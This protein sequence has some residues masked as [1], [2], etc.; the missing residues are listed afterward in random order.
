MARP[1]HNSVA[2]PGVD[3]TEGSIVVEDG[4]VGF[5]ALSR[6]RTAVRKAC[7]RQPGFRAEVDEEHHAEPGGSRRLTDRATEA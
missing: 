4:R 2:M 5:G 7:S 6:D 3:D 1:L